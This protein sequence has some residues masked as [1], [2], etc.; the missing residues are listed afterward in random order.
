MK[1]VILICLALLLAGCGVRAPTYPVDPLNDAQMQAILGPK[2]TTTKEV[3]D[4]V[5]VLQGALTI[6]ATE[7]RDIIVE[8]RKVKI[9]WLAGILGFVAVGLAIAAWVSPVGRALLVK[10]TAGCV[11]VATM[12]LFVAKWAAYFEWIGAGL[13]VAIAVTLL[14]LWRNKAHAIQV[15]A[16]H[17]ASYADKLGD[18]APEVRAQLDRLSQSVQTPAVKAIIDKALDTVKAPL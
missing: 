12:L 16:T 5:K 13:L 4:R 7:R 10:G 1:P 18:L 11:A 17:F 15:L 8:N 9:L 6:L 14:I 2:A 3:D